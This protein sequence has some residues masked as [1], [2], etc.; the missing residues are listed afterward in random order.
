MTVLLPKVQLL[1]EESNSHTLV[2]DHSSKKGLNVSETEFQSR[3]YPS[4]C[5][6]SRAVFPRIGRRVSGAI[7]HH[8]G[9]TEASFN[10]KPINIEMRVLSYINADLAGNAPRITP[11]RL[12]WRTTSS[13]GHLDPSGK[14]ISAPMWSI[15]AD[16]TSSA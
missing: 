11:R 7:F 6:C 9:R 10:A 5:R 13:P 1:Y 15:I 14:K 4:R 12:P 3:D 2:L 8:H 16:V